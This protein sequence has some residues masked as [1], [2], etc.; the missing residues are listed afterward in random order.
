MSFFLSRVHAPRREASRQCTL[1]IPGTLQARAHPSPGS[2]G[3]ECERPL[4]CRGAA[5]EAGRGPASRWRPSGGHRP[6]P[7]SRRCGPLTPTAPVLV[8][9][10]PTPSLPAREGVGW[11][12]PTPAPPSRGAHSPFP[13]VGVR[14]VVV[15]RV[16]VTSVFLGGET[17]Q[18]TM[19][20]KPFVSS[21]RPH[22]EGPI[23]LTRGEGDMCVGGRGN[24]TGHTR[25]TIWYSQ[26]VYL[27]R[28]I[29]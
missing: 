18:R 23:A 24:A 3:S 4:K 28:I 13:G 14:E 19:R 21:L 26:L 6:P 10:Y 29:I 17:F 7:V 5:S 16:V 2:A 9:G 15:R 22:R 27:Y 11:A 8:R 12:L 1:T 20:A 25:G